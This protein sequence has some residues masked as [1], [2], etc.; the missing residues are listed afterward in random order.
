MRNWSVCLTGI[1]LVAYIIS[2]GQLAH[3]D[4]KAETVQPAVEVTVASVEAGNLPLT[5]EA[6]GRVESSASVQ[7]KPRLDGQVS[8]V[9][10]Q[11]GEAVR[12]GQ[13]LF[14]LDHGYLTAQLHQAQAVVAR[15]EVQLDKLRA[16]MESQ[17]TLAQQG[18]ISSRSLA[19]VQVNVRGMQATLAANRAALAA[20]RLQVGYTRITSPIDGIA[21]LLRVPVGSTVKA[22]ET[23]L[24]TINQVQPI[25]VGFTVPQTRLA[26]VR[27]ALQ[28]GPASVVALIEGAAL[29][30][31]GRLSAIDNSMD[32][33]SGSI[34]VKATFDNKSMAL[35]PGQHVKVVVSTGEVQNAVSVPSEVIESG[36]NG[37]FAFVVEDG[38][39][40]IR[41]VEVG[42]VIAGRTVITKGL[43]PGE[44]VVTSGQAR[45]REGTRVRPGGTVQRTRA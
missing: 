3:G 27:L 6:S 2:R 18:F 11:E 37:F 21:G 30:E 10:F 32:P 36:N 14:V 41:T 19:D 13:L 39:A 45:L 31:Q 26:E 40:R 38:A 29:Q 43:V 12:R 24:V 28:S 23:T 33:M 17:K 22:N 15:S 8:E 9:R 34:G 20:S 7:V 16:D 44:K 5:F 42:A 35:T 25:H 1:V 4:T